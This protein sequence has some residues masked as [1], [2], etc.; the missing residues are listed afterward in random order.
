[1]RL[2]GGVLALALVA[3]VLA[4]EKPEDVAALKQELA[5]VKQQLAAAKTPAMSPEAQLEQAKKTFAAIFQAAKTQA[6]P[7]CK[8][9]KGVLR[10]EIDQKTGNVVV[11][12]DIRE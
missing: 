11:A 7:G 10:V 5:K 3:P 2:L 9:V 8:A 12:C 1:M 4:Q 6:L